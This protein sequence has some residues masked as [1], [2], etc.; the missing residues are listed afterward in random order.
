MK[1]LFDQGTPLPLRTF[2]PEGSVTTA[3]QRGWSDLANGDL[4]ALAEGDGFDVLVTT[5]TNLKDQQNLSDRRIAI[6]VVLQPAWPLL[7]KR[8]V[9]GA[10]RIEALEAGGL[11]GNLARCRHS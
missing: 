8:A 6:A 3:A 9:E 10:E 11:R 1:I 4:I 5:D 2:L 7:K